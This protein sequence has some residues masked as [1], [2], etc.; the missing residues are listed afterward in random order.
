M[1]WPAAN[2][3]MSYFLSLL[4]QIR[5]FVGYLKP[6]SVVPC[7]V[8]GWDSTLLDVAQRLKDLL[9]VPDDSVHG[10]RAIATPSVNGKDVVKSEGVSEDESD[11]EGESDGGHLQWCSEDG[12]DSEYASESESRKDKDQAEK[13]SQESARL[14]PLMLVPSPT[15]SQSN[16]SGLLS[17]VHPTKLRNRKENCGKQTDSYQTSLELSDSVDTDASLDLDQRQQR[18]SQHRK[19]AHKHTSDDV[20]TSDK[21]RICSPVNLTSNTPPCSH[22]EE[23]IDLTLS[24][25]NSTSTL[26]AFCSP[27]KCGHGNQDSQGSCQSWLPATPDMASTVRTVAFDDL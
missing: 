16:S 14:P 27:L 2:L 24:P 8:T 9:R 20:T 15:G 26:E 25:S 3:Y 22:T 17:P 7:V 23:V 11:S 12:T 6:K 21:K 13:L 5:E 18:V 1:Q 10:P 19:Q 4:L